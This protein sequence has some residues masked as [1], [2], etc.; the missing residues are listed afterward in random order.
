[1][2]DENTVHHYI[3]FYN[4]VL[5]YT[6]RFSVCFSANSFNLVMQQLKN[7]SRT[8]STNFLSLVML[9]C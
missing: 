3:F 9:S 2:T 8:S 1:M 4:S 5:V 6:T 7:S